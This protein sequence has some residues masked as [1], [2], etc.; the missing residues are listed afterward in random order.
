MLY[1]PRCGKPM[2]LSGGVI[3]TSLECPH[4]RHVFSVNLPR[5][6]RGVPPP[7][8]YGAWGADVSP[9]SRLVAGLLGL[10]LGGF[11][12]HRFYLGF[13]GIGVLQILVTLITWVACVRIHGYPIGAIWGI[14]E[15][16][17]ILAGRMRDA[18]GRKVIGP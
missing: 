2:N 17:L 1:C 18:E 3:P 10:L 12:I 14:I 13:L 15:G 16:I 6:E 5:G 9:H 11:G 7:L 8:P 4:C